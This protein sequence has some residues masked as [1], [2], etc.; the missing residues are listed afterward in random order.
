MI[1][2][3]YLPRLNRTAVSRRDIR[4]RHIDPPWLHQ[5]SDVPHVEP[6]LDPDD[7]DL[8][9][10]I[11]ATGQIGS[12]ARID[13]EFNP[14]R[15]HDRLFVNEDRATV[16]A[17]NAQLRVVNPNIGREA[18][19][20]RRE[21][22]RE[23]IEAIK[24]RAAERKAERAERKRR[25]QELFFARLRTEAEYYRAIERRREE[26]RKQQQEWITAAGKIVL[27]GYT[28]IEDLALSIAKYPGI[29]S[30]DTGLEIA[31][32]MVEHCDL[33]KTVLDTAFVKKWME[34]L[35]V[36]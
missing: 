19:R 13:P 20:H 23:E 16:E 33:N 14:A 10:H 25:E 7:Y 2:M 4:W 5:F 34:K 26:Q 9:E 29:A 30:A 3:G 15:S 22:A 11:R 36:P 8:I 35:T 31:A 28:D 1:I 6:R 24:A 32:K 18:D 27:S 21:L 12:G 17:T